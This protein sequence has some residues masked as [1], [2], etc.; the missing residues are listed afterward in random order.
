MEQDKF[1]LDRKY[2]KF[3]KNIKLSLNKAI[4]SGNMEL[5][6]T[7]NE[8]LDTIEK[9]KK[10][11]VLKEK[12]D[13]RTYSDNARIHRKKL[14]DLQKKILYIQY[15]NPSSTFTNN[16]LVIDVPKFK[17]DDINYIF[18]FI[19]K[20]IKINNKSIC[21]I[22][23]N[24]IDDLFNL[25]ITDINF[26]EICSSKI[27]DNI[28]IV[29]DN[30]VKKV[31]YI[32]R[33]IPSTS[34]E[35]TASKKVLNT[36]VDKINDFDINTFFNKKE[37]K[38]L[39]KLVESNDN[40]IDDSNN[41]IYEK[42]P[43]NILISENVDLSFNK[44]SDKELKIT[45]AILLINML[46][47]IHCD[48][49]NKLSKNALKSQI[50]K[51]LTLN[52]KFNIEK[53]YNLLYNYFLTRDLDT[54]DV[55]TKKTESNINI[56]IPEFSL[57]L[58]NNIV[59]LFYIYIKDNKDDI[60]KNILIFLK[61]IKN[62]LVKKTYSSFDD[63][64]YFNSI[65][66]ILSVCSNSSRAEHLINTFYLKYKEYD[67]ILISNL[68]LKIIENDSLKIKYDV[69]EDKFSVVIINQKT[70]NIDFKQIDKTKLLEGLNN[71]LKCINESINKDLIIKLIDFIR[72]S[73][74][75]II[76]IVSDVEILTSIF[77]LSTD[78]RRIY[79]YLK[80]TKTNFKIRKLLVILLIKFLVIHISKFYLDPNSSKF[81]MYDSLVDDL[82]KHIC[83]KLTVDF[84][85]NIYR[86]MEHLYKDFPNYEIN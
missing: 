30:R 73:L 68:L 43:S 23:K 47:N 62:E 84:S 70:L 72:E 22:L 24:F 13:V 9:L 15:N 39:N 33:P 65:N 67:K 38:T 48:M 10:V 86:K 82:Y 41:I 71:D 1:F 85:Y 8:Y 83:E 74:N 58:V 64:S 61:N 17:N 50:C 21:I 19:Y 59:I 27:L 18:M 81:N 14:E 11:Y 78:S 57:S 29:Y 40:T 76:S 16:N 26:K 37:T 49:K 35:Y 5:V 54:V 51:Y 20:F 7:I 66:K 12:N 52:P 53:E 32:Y 31:K 69:V 3:I 56:V 63:G 46:K 75:N 34:G 80:N 60:C 6:D 36:L 42:P 45:L 79:G 28:T 55:E 77:N 2:V 4:S 25:N 44:K